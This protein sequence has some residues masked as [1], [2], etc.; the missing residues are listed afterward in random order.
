M[1]WIKPK[2]ISRYCPFKA[3]SLQLLTKYNLSII[4][5]PVMEKKKQES[6]SPMSGGC[7]EN[8]SF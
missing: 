6:Q 1:G 8:G 4:P 3:V 7:R 2:T 5:H